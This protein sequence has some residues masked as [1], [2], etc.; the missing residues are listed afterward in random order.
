MIFGNLLYFSMLANWGVFI[1]TLD[2][3]IL[4]YHIIKRRMIATSKEVRKEIDHH[5]SFSFSLNYFW[6]KLLSRLKGTIKEKMVNFSTLFY[7]AYSPPSRKFILQNLKSNFPRR[8]RLYSIPIPWELSERLISQLNFHKFDSW[9]IQL[10]LCCTR[11]EVRWPN[12]SHTFLNNVKMWPFSSWKNK[13]AHHNSENVVRYVP[14][15]IADSMSR[16]VR[17]DDGCLGDGQRIPG[18]LDRGVGEVNQDTQPVHLLH[19]SLNKKEQ[20]LS[21]CNCVSFIYRGDKQFFLSV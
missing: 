16:G 11:T 20:K 19:N 4:A 10:I 7:I 18:G 3:K 1:Y 17:K 13:Y 6:N 8:Y 14:A 5:Q 12:P 9:W 2:M 15:C 21:L